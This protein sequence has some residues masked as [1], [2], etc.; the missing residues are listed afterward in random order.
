MTTA[1][2]FCKHAPAL[3]RSRPVSAIARDIRQE[4]AT[5]Y[6]G[7]EPYLNAMEQL[8]TIDDKYGCDDA[9]SI[10]LYF[11]SNAREFRG[12]L[13]KILKAELKALA[14]VK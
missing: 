4:W 3:Q 8:D 9:K 5:P 1:K 11:L 7:A 10:V 13:A 12:P 14:G 2:D 6:F